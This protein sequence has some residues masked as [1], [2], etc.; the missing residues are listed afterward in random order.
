MV[1]AP[2]AMSAAA[3]D[4]LTQAGMQ[5]PEKPAGQ[6]FVPVRPQQPLVTQCP[7]PVQSPLPLHGCKPSQNCNGAHAFVPSVVSKQ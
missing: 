2:L 1:S 5:V 4:P 7:P 6:Q 3:A